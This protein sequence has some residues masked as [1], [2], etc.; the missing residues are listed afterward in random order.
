[1]PIC[2]LGKYCLFSEINL[3]ITY[4]GES[5]RNTAVTRQ[6]NWTTEIIEN[7][8]TNDY[9]KV[10]LPSVFKRSARVFSPIP[11]QFLSAQVIYVNY[12]N[13]RYKI[14]AYGKMNPKEFS[15]FD[16]SPLVARC[17]LSDIKQHI[18]LDSSMVSTICKWDTAEEQS[19]R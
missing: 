2:N 3:H 17:E 8:S 5:V 11:I 4:K 9:G 6:I 13:E 18:E 1:M 19:A 16:G 14:W 7:F 10:K 15:E 12:H